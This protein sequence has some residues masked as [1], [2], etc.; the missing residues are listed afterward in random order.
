MP[1]A[2]RCSNR[3]RAAPNGPSSI[4]AA[5][6]A[7]IALAVD[8]QLD[9]PVVEVGV[10]PAVD[11]G[12]D[13]QAVIVAEIGDRDRG[14]SLVDAGKGRARDLDPDMHR[15]DQRARLVDRVVASWRDRARCRCAAGTRPPPRRT[16]RRRPAWRRRVV[17]AST[18]WSAKIGPARRSTP[19]SGGLIRPTFQPTTVAAVERERGVLDGIGVGERRRAR[20][21]DSRASACRRAARRRRRAR[22]R[23]IICR[24]ASGCT[25]VPL[26][27]S[28]LLRTAM[29]N[30]CHCQA[31]HAPNT[32]VPV[33]RECARRGRAAAR[34]RSASSP[35]SAGGRPMPASTSAIDHRVGAAPSRA[36][37]ASRSPSGSTIA[38]PLRARAA[39]GTRSSSRTRR[40]RAAA[41]ARRGG[42]RSAC[43]R[44]GRAAS[45]TRP[46]RSGRAGG[47]SP[48]CGSAAAPPR[49]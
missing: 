47:R 40:R 39:S 41:S 9:R 34:R 5:V 18:T 32:R 7:P 43:R 36:S 44:A 10:A 28:F 31:A 8:Q 35:P 24:L 46:A 12:A 1:R 3:K 4:V 29:G 42:W 33:A 49:R 6:A 30:R 20:R 16:R 15:V 22:S 11:R 37:S 17:G 45:A 25:A 13:D 14:P 21:R 27:L 19:S 38:T 26:P 48:D 23:S 2:A